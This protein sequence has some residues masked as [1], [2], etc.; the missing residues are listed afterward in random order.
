MSGGMQHPDSYSFSPGQSVMTENDA[1]GGGLSESGSATITNNHVNDEELSI[2]ENTISSDKPINIRNNRKKVMVIYLFK[3]LFYL[4]FF[5]YYLN[6][7][8]LRLEQGTKSFQSK[9][10]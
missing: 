10:A 5:V 8:N 1:V 7:C 9:S 3:H 6:L 4:F 2:S